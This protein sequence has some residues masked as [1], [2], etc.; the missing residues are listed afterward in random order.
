MNRVKHRMRCGLADVAEDVDNVSCGIAANQMTIAQTMA[1][2]PAA[3]ILSTQSVA[4]DAMG[5]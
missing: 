3:E 4:D 5:I 1:V 2:W